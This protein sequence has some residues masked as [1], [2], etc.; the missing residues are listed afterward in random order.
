[1]VDLNQIQNCDCC[2]FDARALLERL[3]NK[4]LMFVGDSLAL[5][6]Y[7]SL[8]CMIH[9]AVPDAKTTVSPRSGKINPSNTVTFEV[10]PPVRADAFSASFMF[11]FCKNRSS[12]V[13][14]ALDCPV[15][16]GRVGLRPGHLGGVGMMR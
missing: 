8:L 15:K 2:R 10:R 3:R 13:V 14:Q 11:F 1:M 7:E 6:Q 5:N 9:A 12:T 4:R 16:S